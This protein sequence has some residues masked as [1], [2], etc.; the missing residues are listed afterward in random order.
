MQGERLSHAV[1]CAFAICL[2]KKQAREKE[3][4]TVT[5]SENGTSF[6]RMGSFRQTT[7]TE[8]LADPQSAIVAGWSFCLSFLSLQLLLVSILLKVVEYCK[9]LLN[10]I[11]LGPLADVN[12]PAGQH[13]VDFSA[14]TLLASERASGL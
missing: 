4:V 11:I 7:L 13:P 3:K 8:R 1:G 6:T 9:S 5:F 2:E 14:L 12:E 10:I